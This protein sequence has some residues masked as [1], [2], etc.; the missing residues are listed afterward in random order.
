MNHP[1]PG[2]KSAE[3][4]RAAMPTKH[5]NIP[6]TAEEIA[7]LVRLREEGEIY[8]VCSE[9]TGHTVGACKARYRAYLLGYVNPT[10]R[11]DGGRGGPH[12]ALSDIPPDVLTL[13]MS[14]R[15]AA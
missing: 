14:G 8:K 1:P 15:W 12:E 4:N 2:L 5:P 10:E 9:E 7:T 3:Y 6:W 11:P 13:A